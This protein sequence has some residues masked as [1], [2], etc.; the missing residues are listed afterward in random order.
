MQYFPLHI[1]PSS[2]PDPTAENEGASAEHQRRDICR[3]TVVAGCRSQ[4]GTAGKVHHQTSWSCTSPSHRLLLLLW[5]APCFQS[6]VHSQVLHIEWCT[7]RTEGHFALPGL[8]H[9]LQLL[10]I[11]KQAHLRLSVLRH[12]PTCCWSQRHHILWPPTRLDAVLLGV[13]IS[14][15]K[16]FLL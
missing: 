15:C 10:Q 13:C 3:S 5:G 12:S 7:N 14:D 2:I 1:S 4:G 9:Y 8:Q 16:H 11:W 6:C